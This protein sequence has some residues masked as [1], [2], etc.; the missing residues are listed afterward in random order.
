M[1]NAAYFCILDM[2]CRRGELRLIMP[3]TNQT[4]E[5]AK[6]AA[7]YARVSL[8]EQAE[9]YSIKGQLDLLRD[10]ARNRGYEVVAQYVDEGYSGTTGDRPELGRLMKDAGAKR[11]D[12][13]LVYR[14][15]RF[16]RSLR[17]LSNAVARLESCG[18]SLVSATEPFDTST[19]FGKFMLQFL[20]SMA[21]LD[22]NI[23]LDRTRVG[24]MRRA[25]EGYWWGTPPYGYVCD[26]QAKRLVICLEEVE[27][28][29]TAFDLYLQPGASLWRVA[30]DL[31]ALGYRTRKGLLWDT[32]ALHDLLANPAHAGEAYL[33]RIDGKGKLKP[34][35]QWIAVKVPAIVSKQAFQQ[36]QDRMR[37]RNLTCGGKKRYF[38]LLERLGLCGYCGSTLGGSTNDSTRRYKGKTYTFHERYYRCH[39]RSLAKRRETFG[40]NVNPTDQ[41]KSS[42][43]MRAVKA[44]VLENVI[45]NQVKPLLLDP[46]RVAQA[47]EELQKSVHEVNVKEDLA[48]V[49]KLK[50]RLASK[51]QSL[52]QAYLA[53]LLKEEEFS[54]AIKHIKDEEAELVRRQ[55]ELESLSRADLGAAVRSFEEFASL[56]A[57]DLEALPDEEKQQV[58]Q[59]LVD[60]FI[61]NLDGSVVLFLNIP[62]KEQDNGLTLKIETR[63][64]V[65]RPRRSHRLEGVEG[66]SMKYENL[67]LPGAFYDALREEAEREGTTAAARMRKTVLDWLEKHD[68]APERPRRTKIEYLEDPRYLSLAL[69]VA[70]VR[71]LDSAVWGSGWSKMTLLRHIIVGDPDVL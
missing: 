1:S 2:S 43:P 64:P 58:I 18:V 36:V 54:Q 39:G 45:W 34:R 50:E 33:N 51:R 63:L 17:L 44:A 12:I 21:E 52:L 13:L 14:V 40:R 70:A 31:N 9:N 57:S 20:G 6:R 62:V 48:R 47:L 25:R 4:N 38:Y 69:P 68:V 66:N 3:N 15:D 59:Q 55:A 53:D 37:E 24:R 60:R 10:F 46:A 5:R 22:R 41:R 27:V 7:L 23:I 32:S 28:V 19:P 42:C 65:R 35:D 29:A 26:K 11:F 16:F 71:K 61:L 56:Y 49:T 67:C 30:K 8:E